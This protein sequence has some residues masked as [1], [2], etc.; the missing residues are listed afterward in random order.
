MIG[1]GFLLLGS[2]MSTRLIEYV[3]SPDLKETR[4]G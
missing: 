2:E 4:S 1:H 3:G